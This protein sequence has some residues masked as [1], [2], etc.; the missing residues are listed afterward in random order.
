MPDD[1]FISGLDEHGA[2]KTWTY[3]G[4]MMEWAIGPDWQSLPIGETGARIRARRGLDVRDTEL[5][6][7]TLER[8]HL[9]WKRHVTPPVERIDDDVLAA[10]DAA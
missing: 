2:I 6:S 1:A 3:P 8:V 9:A 10:Y 7:T 4:A 5:V